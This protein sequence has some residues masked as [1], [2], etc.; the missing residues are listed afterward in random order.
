MLNID[1]PKLR[2]DIKAATNHLRDLKK[3][4]RERGQPRVTWKIRAEIYTWKAQ[5][6]MLCSLMA[7]SRGRIHRP[8]K[9]TMEEQAAFVDPVQEQ[10]QKAPEAPEVPPQKIEQGEPKALASP[11]KPPTFWESA[12]GAILRHLSP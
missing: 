7:H 11:E 5:A 4:M 1:R 9:M 12:K 10:Y 2:A 6:T 3:V 8:G